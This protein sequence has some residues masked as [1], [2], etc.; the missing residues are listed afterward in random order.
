M[1]ILHTALRYPPASGGAEK[2]IQNIVQK[3]RNVEKDMDVRVLTS[4]MRTHGPISYL[5]P[6]ALLD[7]PP[8]VQRLF[9]SRTPLV[10]YPRLQALNYYIGH[11]K[12]DILHSYGYWYQ[13][14]DTTARYA[15]KHKIPFIFHPIYY[16]NSVRRKPIWKAY[17]A[18][19]GR[20]TFE[21][22]DAVAVIS[23]YEKQLIVD[24]GYNVKRFVHIPPGVDMK[25]FSEKRENPF[26]S[27]NISGTI[28]LSISRIAKSK[29]LQDTIRALPEIRKSIPGACL[30]IIGEDFG[31]KKELETI[32]E[33]LGVTNA[34][35]YFGKAT[36]DDVIA[37]LQH[38]DVFIH[39]STYE[40][41]GIVLAEAM[42]AGL[43]IVARESTAIPYVVP[44]NKAGLL[45]SNK[46]ELVQNVISIIKIPQLSQ[47]L[48][49]FS[50]ELVRTTYSWE[51]SI[52]TLE[53][54]YEEF[55]K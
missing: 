7:D 43:P 44:K 30:V 20:K 4:A 36:D 42:A 19:I 48:T 22:A 1:R 15:K 12:P 6:D 45:F 40:A 2:Y 25:L 13:P 23:E 53:S 51:H 18:L 9:V 31:Y 46:K 37:A 49:D 34:V 14:A 52:K 33:K 21:Q 35:H 39:A 24:A 55:R 8:Y 41:F 54:L 28:L 32:A 5:N 26:V 11:H 10:S 3:T 38:A 47:H 17:D 50:A 29:G 16:T 27:R